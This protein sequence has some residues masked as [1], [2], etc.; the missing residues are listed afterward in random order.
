MRE[1]DDVTAE[2]NNE[3]VK[4]VYWYSAKIVFSK[5]GFHLGYLFIYFF[6]RME[7][8][9]IKLEFHLGYFFFYR[10]ELEFR[11]LEFQVIFFIFLF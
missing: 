2:R 8:E 1:R 11:K 4:E 7:L 6:Y 10:M 3:A 9:F 5:L